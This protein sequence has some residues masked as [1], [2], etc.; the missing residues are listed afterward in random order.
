MFLTLVDILPDVTPVHLPDGF[1]N[2]AM[3]WPFVYEN[4]ADYR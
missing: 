1:D 3:E 4:A 2:P